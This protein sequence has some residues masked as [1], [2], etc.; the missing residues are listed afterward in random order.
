MN[1]IAE[2]CNATGRYHDAEPFYKQSLPIREKVLGPADGDT[3][4]SWNNLAHL[5]LTLSRHSEAEACASRAAAVC[6]ALGDDHPASIRNINVLVSIYRAKG[7]IDKA[8][9]ITATGAI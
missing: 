9:E 6:N 2:L 1:N 8:S 4:T 5:Y 3:A 7:E